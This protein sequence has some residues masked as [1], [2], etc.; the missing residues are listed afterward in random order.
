MTQQPHQTTD[1]H[2]ELPVARLAISWIL[3]GVPL[4]W[5]V[6]Q[7]FLKA[8]PLFQPSAGGA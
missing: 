3:V 2:P 4:A 8:L 5:G 7:T 6:F 1:D